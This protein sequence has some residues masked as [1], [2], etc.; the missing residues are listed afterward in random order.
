[1]HAFAKLILGAL[2]VLCGVGAL[3]QT[4]THGVTLTWTWTGNGTASFNVYRSTV[5]GGETQPALASGITTPVFNDV[6]AA[7]NTMYYYTVTL[8]VGGIESAPSPEVSAQIVPPNAPT[9]PETSVH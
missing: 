9:N 5:S 1:M 3:S 8:V 4:I 2:I 6:T 7:V